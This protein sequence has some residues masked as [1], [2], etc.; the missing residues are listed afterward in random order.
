MTSRC[1]ILIKLVS[2][3]RSLEYLSID[4]YIT[5]IAHYLQWV[6]PDVPQEVPT[7]ISSLCLLNDII[8]SFDVFPKL[9]MGCNLNFL[10][11]TTSSRV[12]PKIRISSKVATNHD[13]PMSD[14]HKIGVDQ[15]V[16]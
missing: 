12:I 1:P 14:P 3:K 2:I 8:I 13:F 10:D 9:L 15:K 4:T 11:Q 5:R 7:I 6:S 16:S